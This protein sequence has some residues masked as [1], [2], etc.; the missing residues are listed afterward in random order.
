[1]SK[2]TQAWFAEF[3]QLLDCCVKQAR[4][5]KGSQ[6]LEAFEIF[7]SLLRRI[8]EGTDDLL[9]FADEGGSWQVGVDWTKVL[10]AW[11]A[12]LSRVAGPEEYARRRCRSHRCIYWIR[13]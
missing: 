8:D 12:C 9:F 2:G 5:Y 13:A 7:F 1:M 6:T 3:G 4:K 11:L 10:P